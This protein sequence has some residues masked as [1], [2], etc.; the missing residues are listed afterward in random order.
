[1]PVGR[2]LGVTVIAA[3]VWAYAVQK[4]A[5]DALHAPVIVVWLAW[6]GLV[7]VTVMA[8]RREREVRDER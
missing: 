4:R 6:L 2:T 7:A 8:E 3:I 5:V 1:M